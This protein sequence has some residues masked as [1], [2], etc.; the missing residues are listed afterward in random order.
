MKKGQLEIVGLIFLISLSIVVTFAL[1]KFTL[2][3]TG[4]NEGV[5]PIKCVNNGEK[6][7]NNNE[8][9]SGNCVVFLCADK[10]TEKTVTIV[11]T[12]TL[13]TLEK[14]QTTQQNIVTTTIDICKD[15]SFTNCI[16][17][18]GCRWNG[19]IHMGRCEPL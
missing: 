11:T 10:I 8:C 13:V 3:Q 14:T 17:T 7:Q 18:P 2:Y 9:C 1:F 4:T 16:Y 12:T 15:R 6:C 5:N 19:S